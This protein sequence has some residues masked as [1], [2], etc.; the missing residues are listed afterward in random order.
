M[1]RVQFSENVL[2]SRYQ[3]EGYLAGEEVIDRIRSE[4]KK[5]YVS[6]EGK[7]GTLQVAWITVTGPFR[8]YYSLFLQATATF[9]YYALAMRQTAMGLYV[10]AG[11]QDHYTDMVFL[12]Y[13]FGGYDHTL[14]DM[15]NTYSHDAAEI[16]S[17]EPINL[18]NID[19]DPSILDYFHRS[20]IDSQNCL[21]FG[22]LGGQCDGISSWF[23]YLYFKT[24][25]AFV[26]PEHHLVAVTKQLSDGAGREAAL[27]QMAQCSYSCP[28]LGLTQCY[29]EELKPAKADDLQ[30]VLENLRPGLY[31]VRTLRKKSWIA[32]RMNLAVTKDRAYLID[33]SYGLIKETFQYFSQSLA[34]NYKIEIYE[35]ID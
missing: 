5:P 16:Y 2:H 12:N 3:F 30:E 34:D 8:I 24:K 32:H 9:L 7:L 11:R 23:S 4:A 14:V 1:S 22:E 18:E 20:N 31:S 19:L 6:G 29:V 27:L 26:D 17:H 28:I 15:L 21:T 10:E 33:P 25:D 35:I 13:L